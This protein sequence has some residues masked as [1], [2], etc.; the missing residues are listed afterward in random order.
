[1]SASHASK[2]RSPSRPSITTRA[3]SLRLADSHA[4]VSSASNCRCVN[5]NVGDTDGTTGRRTCSAGDWSRTPSM[6]AVR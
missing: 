2:I 1:M 3:K 4:A 5:P 6:T